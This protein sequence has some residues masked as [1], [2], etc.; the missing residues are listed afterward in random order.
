MGQTQ[1][2]LCHGTPPPPVTGSSHSR[3]GTTHRSYKHFGYKSFCGLLFCW[4]CGFSRLFFFYLLFFKQELEKW[5]AQKFYRYR[6]QQ[7]RRKGRL[8]QPPSLTPFYSCIYEDLKQYI[9][10]MTKNRQL[11]FCLNCLLQYYS[12]TRLKVE[13]ISNSHFWLKQSSDAF[14]TI[15]DLIGRGKLTPFGQFNFYCFKILFIQLPPTWLSH[16]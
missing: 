2:L 13:P 7:V 5:K 6:R 8:Y 16:S 12:F 9:W 11:S 14:S 3:E 15:K 4:F 10:K 1:R